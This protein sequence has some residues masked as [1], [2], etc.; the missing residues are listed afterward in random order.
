LR[1]IGD[2]S[3]FE[4]D[5]QKGVAE[6]E[7]KTVGNTAITV[8]FGLNYGGRDEIVRAVRKFAAAG[9]DCGSV[10]AEDISAHLDTAGQPDPDLIIRTSGEQRLSNFLIWQA[11][12][13][14]LF[15]VKSYWPDFTKENLEAA[16]DEYASRKRRMGK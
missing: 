13:S 5:I 16:L 8:N 12:Y 1:A 4:P 11:A 2:M 15:F 14:E 6:W 10:T 3:R 9:G 7:K